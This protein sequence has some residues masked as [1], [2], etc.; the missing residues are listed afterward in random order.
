M[1]SGFGLLHETS[2]VAA[3]AVE[4]AANGTVHISLRAEPREATL[5]LDDVEI[6]NPHVVDVPASAEPHIVE[7]RLEGHT[8]THRA[9]SFA[10]SIDVTLA[11]SREGGSVDTPAPQGTH[12]PSA[13]RSHPESSRPGPASERPTSP[14]TP[15]A[16]PPAGAEPT[17][18][19]ARSVPAPP[20]TPAAEPE[21]E[22]PPQ[23][24]KRVRF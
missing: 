19:V 4:L 22:A 23:T 1:H 17:P 11:L 15:V 2:P 16:P 24:I 5:Y 9:V 8:S 14:A 12:T 7:A 3:P 20:P 18:T 13:H 10:R 6:P 21:T